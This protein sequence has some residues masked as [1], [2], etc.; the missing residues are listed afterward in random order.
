MSSK[1]EIKEE[2]EDEIPNL[3][4]LLD[5]LAVGKESV[6]FLPKNSNRHWQGKESDS[7]ENG[8]DD[9]GDDDE[10]DYQMAFSEFKN[11]CLDSRSELANIL[12]QSIQSTACFDNITE[13]YDFEDP[14]LWETAAEACDILSERVDQYIQNVKDGRIGQYG[15]KINEAVE[16]FGEL[17]RNKVKG[18]LE[19]ILGS[20]VEMEVS[21][22]YFIFRLEQS[23]VI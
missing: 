9:E 1:K 23:S 14:I 7:D 4:K 21:M 5:A 22:Y 17:A 10:F 12:N 2:L 18:G 19:Q 13:N 20:L 16:R 15:E 3:P 6:A 8:D 11:L